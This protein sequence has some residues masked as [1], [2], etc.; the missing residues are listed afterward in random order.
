[1]GVSNTGGGGAA[2]LL[3]VSVAQTWTPADSTPLN[4]NFLPAIIQSSA[5]MGLTRAADG[6][7]FSEGAVFSYTAAVRMLRT[8]AVPLAAVDIDAGWSVSGNGDDDPTFLEGFLGD[9]TR[10]DANGA[11]NILYGGIVMIPGDGFNVLFV[12][13]TAVNPALY[14][15]EM[16]VSATIAMTRVQSRIPTLIAT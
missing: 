11:A 12:G 8:D 9:H 16:T 4:V 10:F 6:I 15:H 2:D 13:A 5:E 3:Y 1:M 14:G 7:H